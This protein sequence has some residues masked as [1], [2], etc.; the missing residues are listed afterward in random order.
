[1]TTLLWIA[2][3]VTTADTAT[4]KQGEMLK[5]RIYLDRSVMEVFANGRQ[6]ITQLIYPSRPDSLGVSLFASGGSVKIKSLNAWD[7]SPTNSW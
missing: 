6:C 1:M 2:V 3:S 5:L 7:I 4:L